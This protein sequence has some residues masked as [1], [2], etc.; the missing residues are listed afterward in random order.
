MTNLYIL[1]TSDL[2]NH[3][4]LGHASFAKK[5]GFSPIFIFP[6]RGN[7]DKYA[8][9]YE[10][11][12]VMGT[13][14]VFSNKNFLTYIFSIISYSVGV[15]KLLFFKKGIKHVLAVDFE[16]TLAS[17]FLKIRG[18]KVYS[19]VNDNFSVRYNL[20]YISFIIIRF[21][22]SI[23]Y[24]LVSNISIF[25]DKSRVQLL[26]WIKPKEI[27]ILPNVL[28]DTVVT[29]YQG[30]ADDNLIVL[31]CGWLD[32][33]RGLELLKKL[34]EYTNEK[35]QFLLVGRGDM[36][37]ID[38]LTFTRRISFIGHLTR[39]KTL[40]LMSTVDINFA[41]YNP[42][43]TINRYAMP[44]KVSDSLLVGC[45]IIINSEVQMAESLFRSGS[46]FSAEY[47]DIVGISSILNLLVNNKQVLKKN[48]ECCIALN[49]KS[50]S[51]KTVQNA[52]VAMYEKLLKNTPD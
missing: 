51:Y 15:S 9:Y 43:I 13:R 5:A 48:S 30:N 40:E 28:K 49:E 25:P 3:V 36:T 27:V 31:V 21:F 11:Y 33:T 39:E 35:V 19:L 4:I 2:P 14:T 22:E 46:A 32:K 24:K 38:D 29:R 52:G 42:S 7:G 12:S 44:Q 1:T 23:I 17:V 37:V 18:V 50:I 8:S 45:P 10:E 6:D 20:G 16:G 47:W 41:F 34:A 26:G